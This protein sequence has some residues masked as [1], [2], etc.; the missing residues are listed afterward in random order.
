MF[1]V[2][3]AAMQRQLSNQH[4]AHQETT[5][6]QAAHQA[7]TSTASLA[8]AEAAH[9]A[10]MQQSEACASQAAQ[11]LA[12]ATAALASSRQ[13]VQQ[14]QGDQARLQRE[15]HA[16]HAL[17][18]QQAQQRAHQAS[19]LNCKE[20][21]TDM[22]PQSKLQR[23]QHDSDIEVLRSCVRLLDACWVYSINARFQCCDGLVL[24]AGVV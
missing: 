2:Q 7:R 5:A 13:L 4:T 18:Q 14:L 8:A 19:G 11:E 10:A 12:Q 23:C 21:E 17:L 24:A 1:K 9:R 15:L 6:A 16:S 22:Q 20:S 3:H